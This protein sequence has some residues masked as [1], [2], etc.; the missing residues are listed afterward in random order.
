MGNEFTAPWTSTID[1]KGLWR[2]SPKRDEKLW[3]KICVEKER[4]VAEAIKYR[5]AMIADGWH[6][7]PLYNHEPVGQAS[8]MTR[9]GF[10]AHVLSRPETERTTPSA[11]VHFWG[12][13]GM[14]IRAPLPYDGAA[15]VVG[16]R[17]CGYCGASDVDTQQVAFAG[18]A[19]ASCAPKEW[20]KLP[21][22]WS[23]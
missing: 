6:C 7:E 15:V 13:D 12:P 10:I 9:D 5:A 20:A 17:V 14:A 19:C 3:R 16:L 21:A 23:D 2:N 18:R 11:S 4:F 1:A 8:R 22:N